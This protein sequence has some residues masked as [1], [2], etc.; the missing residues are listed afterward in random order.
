MRD[1]EHAL[2]AEQ[3]G[4]KHEAREDRIGDPPTQVAQDLRVARDEA[5][6]AERV[7][8]R[9]HARDDG[10]TTMRHAVEAAEGEPLRERGVRGQQ[11]IEASRRHCRPVALLRHHGKD[12]RGPRRTRRWPPHPTA[13][14]G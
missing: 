8:T 5:Q 7:D 4:G 6:H 9:V 13:A 14:A 12:T 11:I 3:V 2:D 10:D 1:E